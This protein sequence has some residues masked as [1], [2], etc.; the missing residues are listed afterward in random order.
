[1]K[2]IRALLT[3]MLLL[4]LFGPIYW[5]AA[6]SFKG[7]MEIIQR[8]PTAFPHDPTLVNFRD[9]FAST[10]YSTYLRNSIVVSVGTMV[11]TLILATLASYALYRLRPR[12]SVTMSNLVLL[13]YVIP[14]TLVLVPLYKL[15]AKM[16]VID[17]LVALVIVNV[18]FSTPFC[19]WLMRGFLD[20]I[21]E[22]LDQAAAVDGAGPMRILIQVLIPLLLPG[23]ATIAIY[24]FI[25]S[26][27][28]F[29][30]ASTFIVSDKWKTLP[31]GLSAIMGQYNINWGLLMAGTL[32]TMLPSA[33]LFGLVGKYFIRGLVSGAIK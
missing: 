1:M 15:L 3:G 18:T 14:S 4:L 20:A 30:F 21:P 17:S 26:W 2:I 29:V 24:S 19:V 13:S 16:G 28:E 11:V 10:D 23:L 32:L 31:I 33:V 5:I 12:G 25:N 9:L 7:P 8:V 27:T 22:E 6:S